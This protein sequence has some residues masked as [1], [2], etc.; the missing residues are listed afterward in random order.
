VGVLSDGEIAINTRNEKLFFKTADG[1]IAEIDSVKNTQ[2]A[3]ENTINSKVFIG[4]QEEYDIAYAEGKIGMGALV[5]ILDENEANSD[6]T[7]AMLGKA[8]IG[9]LLL[10]RA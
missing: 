3:I 10:G 5:I 8:I 1:E 7:T 9:T 2:K 6:A 4:T